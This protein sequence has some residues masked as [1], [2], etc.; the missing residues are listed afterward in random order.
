MASQAE[1]AAMRRA[2]DAAR[3]PTQRISPNPRV[4]CVLLDPTGRILAVGRHQ[5]PGTP[6]AEADALT[7]AGPAA[8]GATAVVT[9]G[10]CDHHGRTGPCTD[11]LI[12]AGVA[13]VVYAADDPNPLAAGGTAVLRAAGIDVEGGVLADAAYALNERWLTAVARSRPYVTWKYAATL[14]GRSAAADGT[15]AWITSPESRR[16]ANC[17]RAE[18]DAVVV[19]TGTVLADDPRL[20]VRDDADAPLPYDEQPLRVVVGD[21]EIP[22]EARVWDDSAPTMQIRTRDVDSVLVALHDLEVRHVWLEGGPRLAGAFVAAGVVDEVVG[23]VAPAFLGAGA[24]AL[25]DAGIDT[26]SDIRRFTLRD[27]CRLGP[28]VRVI[29]R[30]TQ[31]EG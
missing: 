9:L 25:T 19:G 22:D 7:L 29:A 18:A 3:E 2:L 24:T 14:D 5:G 4:G 26:I 10:P 17:R 27:V 11:A 20:T 15:S 1:I 12:A 13:R 8:S 23:Y 6:H 21:R 31:E 28:D 30:P 16:D